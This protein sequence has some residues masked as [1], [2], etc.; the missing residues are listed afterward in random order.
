[1]CIRPVLFRWA[2]ALII[3][4]AGAMAQ[5]LDPQLV[6]PPPFPPIPNRPSFATNRTVLRPVKAM[7]NGF[8]YTAPARVVAPLRLADPAGL[9]F[10]SKEKTVDVKVGESEAKFVFAVTNISKEELTIMS[11]HTSCGCTAARLPSTP[12]VLKPG[13]GGEVG[14]TMNLAGKF[15]TVTKTVTVVSTAGSIPLLVRAVMPKDAYE[16]LQRMGD[17]S[18]NLQIAAADRQVVFR[19]DCARC[20]VEPAV[21]KLGKD[22]YVSACGI[23]HDAEH[24]ATMVPALRGRP[25][26]FSSDYWTQWIRQGKEGS[27]MPSFDQKRGGPLTDEQITSLTSYLVDAFAKEPALVPKQ[28]A[29]PAAPAATGAAL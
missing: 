21:G 6:N 2:L 24:R 18:R 9:Q 17:R 22:L 29:V 23:C 12:W 16:Q 27:L 4:V 7:T 11:V 14:A 20:H 26:A 15:G 3:P 19:G 25:G 13:E 5:A 8:T 28:Q 10:D 1:M